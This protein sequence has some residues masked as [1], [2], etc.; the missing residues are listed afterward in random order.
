MVGA[1]G[2]TPEVLEKPS[3]EAA[4]GMY[5]H[6]AE[7]AYDLEVQQLKSQIKP[8]LSQSHHA[9]IYDEVIDIVTV[10]K[11]SQQ[12]AYI[13]GL[14]DFNWKDIWEPQAKRLR[15]IFSGLVNFCRYK[16]Q[17][18]V[19]ITS[20]KS[21]VQ[22]L[23]TS[24]LE[25]LNAFQQRER[26]L[27]AARA[28]H[29]E[30]LPA[31]W[32]AE[33]KAQ[34]I[35]CVV[36]RL[37]KQRQS[38]DRVLEEAEASLKMCKDRA[39]N[40]QQRISQLREEQAQLKDQVAESPEGLE[41]EIQELRTSLHQKRDFVEGKGDEKR[42]RN[43]RDQVLAK[44]HGHL[45]ALAEILDK[46]TSAAS[47]AEAAREKTRVSQEE[48]S[49]FR[50]A[51]ESQRAE[52][53]ELEEQVRALQTD[54]EHAQQRHEDKVAEL[55]A[56]RQ[57]ALQK[58]Q[59]MHAKRTDEE[60]AYHALQGQ[61]LELEAELKQERR[62]LQAQCAELQRQRQTSQHDREAYSQ[63][64]DRLLQTGGVEA[65]GPHPRLDFAAASPPPLQ[66]LRSPGK[67]LRSPARS[68]GRALAGFRSPLGGYGR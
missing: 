2:S 64:I 11:L 21:E 36:E 41:Q 37:Q 9:D 25:L 42:Q 66:K 65:L 20:L 30:E 49:D 57:L 48:L 59:E 47:R 31:M 10:F 1:N 28:Q 27:T 43:V 50:R 67:H 62:K 23:D 60:R 53:A 14:D 68:P 46:T 55:D 34:E 12:L 18:T 52:R 6:V 15:A 35:R 54:I 29:S 61:R 8:Q 26:E 4:M 45:E 38:A 17:Q 5:Q 19:V 44:V 3:G 51:A 22:T 63:S 24:R 13:N 40:N 16:D 7:F 33:N 32:D 39:A 56:R 58:Q